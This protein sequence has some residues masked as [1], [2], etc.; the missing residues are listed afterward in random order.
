MHFVYGKC[1]FERKIDR[2]KTDIKSTFIFVKILQEDCNLH[3][4]NFK[5]NFAS[6]CL[7]Q[8]YKS[9]VNF[10]LVVCKYIYKLIL[11]FLVQ[12]NKLMQIINLYCTVENVKGISEVPLDRF[13]MS[14]QN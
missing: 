13:K 10:Y 4:E 1:I 11:V 7:Q 12:S 9:R 5:L 14:I 6:C 2:S 8:F 3:F